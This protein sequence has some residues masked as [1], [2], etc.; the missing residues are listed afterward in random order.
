MIML[1]RHDRYVLRAFW[2]AFGA[3][4]LFFSLIVVI[5][6]MSDRLARVVRYW[7][8]LKEAGWNP[9]AVVAEYYAT[10]I[11]F[12]WMQIVPLAAVLAATFAL[13]RLTRHNELSPLVTAGVSTRRITA[14]LL[15]SGLVIG[16]LLFGLQEMLVP[17]LSRRN[18]TLERLLNKHEPARITKVPHFDD[19]GGA[20]LSVATFRPFDLHIE[21]ALLTMREETGRVGDVYWYPLLRWDDDTD[22]WVAER[23][24]S[25]FHLAAGG[26]NPA[27]RSV[28]A[29]DPVP[30]E[31]DI[32][33]F[34]VSVV[35]GAS[36]G[37][38]T[39]ETSKL[40]E[41]DPD[42]AR[43]RV[44]HHQLYAR[45]LTPLILL[46][47]GLPFALHLGRRSAIPGTIAVLAAS[48]V[49]Y[50][51]T[52]LATSLASSGELNPIV[53]AW[54]PVVQFGTIGLA[55]WLTMES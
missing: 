5:I 31:A 3:V 13:S 2:A 46:L 55:L 7:T 28:P 49:Y 20:R 34:E 40:I 52:F 17:K 37:L 14:P 15:I 1:R 54:F 19:P 12:I 11:P 8:P 6:H 42:N 25:R 39:N 41:A 9:L 45:A 27:R 35:K 53:L 16:A 32:Q 24:G 10:L 18:M 43:L 21:G 22:H 23:D 47:M 44:L 4:L 48:A 26:A 33:L 36:L 30:L 38:S 51:A 29:A 50:G